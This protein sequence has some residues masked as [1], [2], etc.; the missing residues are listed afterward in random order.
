MKLAGSGDEMGSKIDEVIMGYDRDKDSPPYGLTGD[1]TEDSTDEK[2]SPVDFSDSLYDRRTGWRS[3]GAI[4]LVTE[5]R[6][7]DDGLPDTPRSRA[8]LQ[9]PKP[10]STR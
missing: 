10:P 9:N 4:C 3:A 2:V 5:G 8:R 6:G 7:T 1:F